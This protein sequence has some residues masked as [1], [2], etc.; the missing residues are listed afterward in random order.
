MNLIYIVGMHI[1]ENNHCQLIQYTLYYNVC[2]YNK[3]STVNNR[4][5]QYYNL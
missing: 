3:N 4:A 5:I 2:E 1:Y